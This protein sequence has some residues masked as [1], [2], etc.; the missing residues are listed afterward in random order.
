MH[1]ILLIQIILRLYKEKL[2]TVSQKRNSC[3]TKFHRSANLK[4]LFNLAHI[5]LLFFLERSEKRWELLPRKTLYNIR[6]QENVGCKFFMHMKVHLNFYLI[7]C[8][9]ALCK[10]YFTKIFTLRK[11]FSEAILFYSLRF[12]SILK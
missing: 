8:I 2:I 1:S 6:R 10:I 7:F 12:S 11:Y 4:T 9:Q 5:Q 3:K